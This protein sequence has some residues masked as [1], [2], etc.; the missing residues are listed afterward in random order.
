MC[1]F[2]MAGLSWMWPEGNCPFLTKNTLTPNNTI[3][4]AIM[5]TDSITV[6]I[7]AYLSLHFG[8]KYMKRR[9]NLSS[10]SNYFSTLEVEIV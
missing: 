2:R 4:A 10:V 3:H 9:L 6:A 1:R 7:I 5:Q 8:C